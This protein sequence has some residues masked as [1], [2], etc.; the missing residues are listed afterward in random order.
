MSALVVGG[1]GCLGRAVLASFGRRAAGAS[2]LSLDLVSNPMATSDM[3]VAAPGGWG[4]AA[5]AQVALEAAQAA[6]AREGLDH[7]DAVVCT[8]GS[9]AG[10][11]ADSKDGLASV[12]SMLV[13]NLQPAVTAAHLACRLLRPGGT[14]VLVGAD[15]ALQPTPG[16]VGYGMAKAATHHLIQSLAVPGSGLPEGAAVL[17]ALPTVIDTPANRAAMP[18]GKPLLLSRPE[19]CVRGNRRR[20]GS[21]LKTDSHFGSGF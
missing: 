6:M 3:V 15:A 12:D 8:A 16:M 21:L 4:A 20:H 1:A 17:G 10:G 2:L 13:A 11:G 19:A 7:L 9:W 18:S 14:L 5:S